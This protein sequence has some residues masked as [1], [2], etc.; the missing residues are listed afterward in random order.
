MHTGTGRI[1]ELTLEDG[2]LYARLACPD[3]LIPG[4]GQ[5]LL[6][7]PSGNALLPVPIFPTDFAPQGFVG[8]VPDAWRPGD[9]LHLRGPLGHGFALP[10]SARKVGLVAFDSPPSRLRGLI[11]AAFRQGSAVVLLCNSIADHLPVEVEV[12]P[13]AA[14]G[15]ILQWADFM[16]LD[17]ERENLNKLKEILRELKPS[18]AGRGAQVLVRTPMPCGG[19]ADCG[20]CALSTRS[21]W[22]LACKDGPVFNLSEI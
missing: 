8:L 17:V 10:L 6:A 15:E 16:A 20:V 1:A 18:Y 7:S 12:Q 5:Y 2:C 22:R 3:A 4:P 13:V 21:D 11:P 19:L 14:L 9:V